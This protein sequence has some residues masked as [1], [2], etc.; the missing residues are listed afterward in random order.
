MFASA[1]YETSSTAGLS[2][3]VLVAQGAPGWSKHIQGS[4]CRHEIDHFAI[5]QLPHFR[6]QSRHASIKQSRIG[7]GIHSLEPNFRTDVENRLAWPLH[8]FAPVDTRNWYSCD[9]LTARSYVFRAEFPQ[10]DHHVR[11]FRLRGRHRFDRRRS[12]RESPGGFQGNFRHRTRYLQGSQ[13]IR[14]S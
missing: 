10:V 8:R 2:R 1:S 7:F 13:T 14:Q 11:P 9:E 6:R 12:P 4:S 5:T 3:S